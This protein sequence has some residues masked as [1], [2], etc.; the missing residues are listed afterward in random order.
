MKSQKISLELVAQLHG[1]CT[2]FHIANALQAQL[3][4]DDPDPKL[5][6]TDIK[7]NPIK[8]MVTTRGK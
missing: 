6:V 2:V 3:G 1:L 4:E 7:G 5:L 8:D